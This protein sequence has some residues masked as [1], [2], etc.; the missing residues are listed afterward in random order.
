MKRAL[1]FAV[2]LLANSTAAALAFKLWNSS[3]M[4]VGAM[5]LALWTIG[6]IGALTG[7]FLAA[8]NLYQTR[9]ARYLFAFA[10]FAAF[11]LVSISAFT[12]EHPATETGPFPTHPW[13]EHGFTWLYLVL[14]TLWLGAEATRSN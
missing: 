5:A 7:G 12:I 14:S 2:F 1:M 8:E 9:N 10:A 3:S 4:A 13:H 11:L 6:S